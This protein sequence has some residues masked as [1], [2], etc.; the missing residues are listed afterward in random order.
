MPLINAPK[1]HKIA[2]IKNIH[3]MMLKISSKLLVQQSG[4]INEKKAVFI[5]ETRET[6]G[7]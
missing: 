6:W 2:Q 5:C 4:K 7:K 3:R 1:T